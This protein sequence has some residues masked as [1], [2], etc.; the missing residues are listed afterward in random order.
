MKLVR[1]D[2][3]PSKILSYRFLLSAL[4][5]LLAACG[6]IFTPGDR[7]NQDS[8]D[9]PGLPQVRSLKISIVD[10]GIYQLSAQDLISAGHG[11]FIEDVSQLSM[12]SRW[13]E[14]PFWTDGQGENLVLRFYG[15]PYE[16]EYTREN[17][18]WLTLEDGY[19][20][21]TSFKDQGWGEPLRRDSSYLNTKLPEYTYQERHV[22]EQNLRYVPQATGQDHWFWMTLSAPQKENFMVEINHPAAS[23]QAHMLLN[24]WGSTEAADSPDHHL[25][26]SINGRLIAEDEWDGQ[27]VHQIEADFPVE[28]LAHGENAF[29]IEA[30]G[31]TGMAVDVVQIDKISLLY[32]R[33]GIAQNDRLLITSY[34]GPIGLSGFD[35]APQIYDI[36]DPNRA[37]LV[38]EDFDL[39]KPFS[40][41][42]GHRY[43]IV[44]PDGYLSPVEISGD[45]GQPDL[46]ATG[47]GADYLAIGP[48]DLLVP[49][50]PLLE[51]RGEQGT[52]TE[53][54]PLGA[55]F[56][57]FN[58]GV[59]EPIAIQEFIRHTAQNWDPSPRY[60]LLVGDATYDP[61]GYIT[62]EG[63][64]R[65][66]TFLVETVYGGETASDIPFVQLD[67]EEG[68]DPWPD[69]AL[70]RMPARTPDQVSVLVEK[71]LNYEQ[72]LTSGKLDDQVLAVADGQETYFKADALDFL[73]LF[74]DRDK[75]E[76]YAPLAGVEDANKIIQDYFS[77][78]N[79][80]IAYFG[81]GSVNMW[82]KDRLFTTEDVALLENK[83]SLPIVVNMTCLTGLFTHPRVD[84]LAEA[85]L[86]QQD[87][88][89][90]AVLAPTSL[91][92]PTDQSFLT[93]PLVEYINSDPHARLGDILLKAQ[94]QIPLDAPGTR[95]VMGTFLLYGD[96]ALE[97]GLP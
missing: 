6:A 20:W 59:R 11:K 28:W 70:G 9:S 81:H 73:E 69:L 64:N 48:T 35:E 84:S 16:S 27:G 71:I 56:D 19:P 43:A 57:Q 8:T 85:L 23:G 92:L 87:G 17:V 5:L 83:E 63:A 95:D 22:A 74:P 34:A 46:H 29:T 66:P 26:V 37:I 53:T 49:L 55:V 39:S 4:S 25:E 72:R 18:Y 68:E 86:W 79:Q 80:I 58:H 60:I 93:R 24:V 30:P 78:G 91:T 45:E 2:L 51:R 54:V 33:L 38:R 41:E 88:G 10:E 15:I 12:Y 97:L 89:A 44:G 77:R 1:S 94:R 65:L 14:Q 36:S 76:L 90:V 13:G 96:P 40:G 32:P 47:K 50:Q 67:Q 52:T 3:I 31:D 7:S 61:K 82:G 42:T 62:P 75:T 21:D